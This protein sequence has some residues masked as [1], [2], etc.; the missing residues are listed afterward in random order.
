MKQITMKDL[1]EVWSH[2]DFSK[3]LLLDVRT[4]EEYEEG[5]VPGSKNIPYDEIEKHSSEFNKFQNIYCY[6][7]S[8]KRVQVAMSVL[9][10]HGHKNVIGVTQAGMPDWIEAGFPVEKKS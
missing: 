3:N 8:G 10:L 9:E 1:H 5:H 6:C 4:P 7:R 2:F